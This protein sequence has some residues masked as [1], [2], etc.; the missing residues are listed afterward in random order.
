MSQV[1][2]KVNHVLGIVLCIQVVFCVVIAIFYGVFR[3]QSKDDYYYIDWTEYSTPV[4]SIIIFFTYFVLINTMI[5][6]SLIVSME[7][8]KL[9]QKYFI[10]KD[11]F[12]Y[13]EWRMK[14]AE[15]KVAS[16]NEELGQIEYVFTDKTGTLTKNLMEFK[17]ATIAQQMFGDVALIAPK[18][19]S[20]KPSTEP[21]F[22]D[23]H[24]KDLLRSGA[25]NQ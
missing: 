9:F 23:E 2:N 14:W 5:P 12:M 4:D 11:K 20:E 21:G 6:I 25:G 3:N 13:S 15:V 16:L 10:N 22:K 24:L 7:M 8:V 17:I 18:G 19:S 1:E